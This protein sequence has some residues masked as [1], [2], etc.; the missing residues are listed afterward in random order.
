M[1]RCLAMNTAILGQLEL[2]NYVLFI[3]IAIQRVIH[4]VNKHA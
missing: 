4:Y 2:G 3:V 1:V